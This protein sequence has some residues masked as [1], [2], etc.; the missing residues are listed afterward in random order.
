MCVNIARSIDL[1]YNIVVFNIPNQQWRIR[2]MQLL[3]L[4]DQLHVGVR[5]ILFKLS[6]TFSEICS[7][8][9]KQRT[10]KKYKNYL[11]LLVRVCFII[12]ETTPFHPVDN[13]IYHFIHLKLKFI[14]HFFIVLHLFEVIFLTT[15]K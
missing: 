3:V 11:L 13:Q 7:I 15:S 10:I 1:F 2:I 12:K 14:L 9:Y 8:Q 5:I 4:F 6:T